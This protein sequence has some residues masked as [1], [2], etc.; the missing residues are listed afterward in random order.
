MVIGWAEGGH[1][2]LD[3]RKLPSHDDKEIEK[4]VLVD[5]GL[6]IVSGLSQGAFEPWPNFF[7]LDSMCDE[8][9]LPS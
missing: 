9:S 6:D 8:C 2:Y 1:Y 5:L 7:F 4:S 3:I